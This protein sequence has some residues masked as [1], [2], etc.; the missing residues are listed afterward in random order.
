MVLELELQCAELGLNRRAAVNYS[1][2]RNARMVGQKCILV[3]KSI[4]HVV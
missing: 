3:I 2:A 1:I 4:K